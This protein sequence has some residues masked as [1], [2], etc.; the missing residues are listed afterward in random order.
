MSVGCPMTDDGCTLLENYK[1]SKLRS[2]IATVHLCAVQKATVYTH[3]KRE[4][5]LNENN[6]LTCRIVGTGSAFVS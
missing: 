4:I 3:L 1:A 2:Q 6:I 5:V